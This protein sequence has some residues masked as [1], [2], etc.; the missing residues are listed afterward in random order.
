VITPPA[1]MPISAP[2]ALPPVELPA[3][4]SPKSRKHPIAMQVDVSPPCLSRPKPRPRPVP[5]RPLPSP[6]P[7]SPPRSSVAVPSEAAESGAASDSTILPPSPKLKPKS[8][9]PR[10]PSKAPLSSP[11]RAPSPPR[12]KRRVH[13]S[14]SSSKSKGR[15]RVSPGRPSSQSKPFLFFLQFLSRA[16]FYLLSFSLRHCLPLWHVCGSPPSR[17]GPCTVHTF[18]S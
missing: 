16:K 17:N 11:S 5:Q 18:F 6:D 1:P 14:S 3:I 7:V 12:K 10:V 15:V 9:K 13:E 2:S 8:R 4:E